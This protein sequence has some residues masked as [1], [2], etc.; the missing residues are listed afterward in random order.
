MANRPLLKVAG[1]QLIT[2]GWFWVI[3][4]TMDPKRV[5]EVE[6]RRAELRAA[7]GVPDPPA[8]QIEP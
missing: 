6:A 1:F 5:A 8:K 3:T 7:F 2:P 4:G